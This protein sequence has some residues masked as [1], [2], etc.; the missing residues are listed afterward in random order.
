V[1]DGECYDLSARYSKYSIVHTLF[2]A[3]QH[4]RHTKVEPKV[5]IYLNNSS[6][7]CPRLRQT[8]W[9]SH[10]LFWSMGGG[11]PGPPIPG[12]ATVRS[13]LVWPKSLQLTETES[14]SIQTSPFF[15]YF[16]VDLL[17]FGLLCFGLFNVMS[18]NGQ[19]L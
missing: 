11:H 15:W 8:A 13:N 5:M 1:L 19:K 6:P 3:K 9:R 7:P 17:R 12:S 10:K 4:S 18:R 2:S 16:D 14:I